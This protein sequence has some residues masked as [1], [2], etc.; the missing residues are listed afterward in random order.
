LEFV[1]VV[2]NS[3]A[4]KTLYIVLFLMNQSKHNL[5]QYSK[6]R[7]SCDVGPVDGKKTSASQEPIHVIT[8]LL[9]MV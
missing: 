5:K 2:D 8:A 7:M 9:K 1:E 4:G 6:Y 3:K